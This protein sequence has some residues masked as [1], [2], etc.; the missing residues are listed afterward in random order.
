MFIGGGTEPW[1]M[2]GLYI[3]E[4]KYLRMQ[5]SVFHELCNAHVSNHKQAQIIIL[6]QPVCDRL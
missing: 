1:Q 5:T 3:S 2:I 4:N 6:Y